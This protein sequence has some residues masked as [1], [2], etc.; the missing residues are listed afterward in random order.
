MKT[1]AK[2]TVTNEELFDEKVIDVNLSGLM[3][4]VDGSFEGTV[5]IESEEHGRIPFTGQHGK[6]D[7]ED[8]W[9]FILENI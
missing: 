1:Y 6:W 3:P 4:N 7:Y 2:Y 9:G 8:E 5:E